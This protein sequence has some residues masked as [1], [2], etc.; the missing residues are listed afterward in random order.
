MTP[1]AA[2][3]SKNKR[4]VRGTDDRRCKG[5]GKDYWQSG[6]RAKSTARAIISRNASLSAPLTLPNR[7]AKCHRASAAANESHYHN[8]V[9]S[10]ARTHLLLIPR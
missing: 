10:P 5:A 7:K 6:H 1:Q 8:L 9:S 3:R 4:V 2:V